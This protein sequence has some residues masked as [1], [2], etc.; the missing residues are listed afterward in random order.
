LCVVL[1]GDD[2]LCFDSVFECSLLLKVCCP[3]VIDVRE[4]KITSM[5][6]DMEGV[7]LIIKNSSTSLI[8]W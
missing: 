4:K 8:W 3:D 1:K 7:E 2:L 6:I 5:E